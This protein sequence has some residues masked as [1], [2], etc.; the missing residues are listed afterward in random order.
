MQ[1]SD[2]LDAMEDVDRLNHTFADIGKKKIDKEA[3]EERKRCAESFK[4]SENHDLTA[5]NRQAVAPH[6]IVGFKRPGL[7]DGVYRQFRLGKYGFDARLDLHGLGVDAAA[8]AVFQFVKESM[9]YDLRTVL[10]VHGKGDRGKGQ[11]ARLKN[12]SLQWLSDMPDV[13]AYHSARPHDGG[14]GAV[15]VLLKKSERAKQKNRDQFRLR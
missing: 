8:R 9:E 13:L 7:Q 14:A 1:D 3:L 15:Y 5:F 10:I 2:F 11:K 12:Y 6:D 4:A